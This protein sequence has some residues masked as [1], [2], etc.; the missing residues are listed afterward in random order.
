MTLI[1]TLMAPIILV[2]L[3][4]NPK[5][6]L[7]N[8]TEISVEMI[9]PYR[10]FEQSPHLITALRDFVVETFAL[11][12]Y[13]ILKDDRVSGIV[14]IVHTKDENRLI[15]IKKQ[16]RILTFDCSSEATADVDEITNE[17]LQHF[18]QAISAL[19]SA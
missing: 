1:T 6:G 16:D 9:E 4:K 19:K 7:K 12:G 2:P 18:E 15:T 8:D 10:T 17:G 11:R 3:F 5:S 14:E 13:D